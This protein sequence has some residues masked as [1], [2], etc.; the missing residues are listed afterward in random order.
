MIEDV[1]MFP[2]VRK[3]GGCKETICL[4]KTVLRILYTLHNTFCGKFP[5]LEFEWYAC[6]VETNFL[7]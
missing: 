6:Q 7:W 3:I 2:W 5:F 1:Y 4:C